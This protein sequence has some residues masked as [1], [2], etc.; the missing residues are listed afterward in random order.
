M[1]NIPPKLTLSKLNIDTLM[2]LTCQFRDGNG[3]KQINCVPAIWDG[4]GNYQKA[5]PIFGKGTGITK[6][7]SC[8]FGRERETQ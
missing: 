2:G 8:Y 6:K 3:K 4:N 7:L 5:F 1:Q